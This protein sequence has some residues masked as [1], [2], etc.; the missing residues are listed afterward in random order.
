MNEIGDF[1]LSPAEEA[2]LDHLV[3]EG[4]MNAGEA[5]AEIIAK[6]QVAAREL[7]SRAVTG[8]VELPIM[9]SSSERNSPPRRSRRGGR[10]FPERHD[11]DV[12]PEHT[13][14]LTEQQTL[15]FEAGIAQLKADGE[16]YR[17]ERD[18]QNGY[19]DNEI[20]ARER[21]RSERRQR[22]LH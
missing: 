22:E 1:H 4:V 17:R 18:R 9:S 8:L 10:A 15:D 21:A 20:A 16:Q 6:R 14:P 11:W 13:Q 7:A 12:P 5:L 19:S 3:D 2:H